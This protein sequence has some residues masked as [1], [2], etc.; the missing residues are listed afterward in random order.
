[1]GKTLQLLA[2]FGLMIIIVGTILYPQNPAFWLTSG[3]STY[4]YIREALAGVLIVQLIAQPPRHIWLRVFS[5][6]LAIGV[7]IWAIEAT[8]AYHMLLVDTLCFL[9]AAL[10][11]GAAALEYDKTALDVWS[12]NKK[13]SV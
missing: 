13:V 12:T 5:G 7:G 11:I 1:M 10:A 9:G 4:Q 8:Y 2:L 6:V 3:F